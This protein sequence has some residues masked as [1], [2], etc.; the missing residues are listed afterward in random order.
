METDKQRQ[1]RKRREAREAAAGAHGVSFE[2]ELGRGYAHMTDEEVAAD[3]KR[4]Y[5]PSGE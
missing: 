1:Q 4:H 5:R 2:D 3:I